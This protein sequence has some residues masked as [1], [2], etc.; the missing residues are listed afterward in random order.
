M[1]R[2]WLL[3]CL[4]LSTA[5]MGVDVRCP[6]CAGTGLVSARCCKTCNSRGKITP[7]INKVMGQELG[8]RYRGTTKNVYVDADSGLLRCP[9]KPDSAMKN[10]EGF[11]ALV[12][13]N[14][15]Q[16]AAV[17]FSVKKVPGFGLDE[18]LAVLKESYPIF[19]DFTY[20]EERKTKIMQNRNDSKYKFA[21]KHTDRFFVDPHC[22]RVI[23]VLD[24]ADKVYLQ[25][26]D[27]ALY[28]TVRT[29]AIKS[30]NIGTTGL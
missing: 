8:E 16:I 26:I 17:T 2:L 18:L 5:L 15:K 23:L 20:R 13:P 28:R 10:A 12:T 11:T 30:S 25:Y 19:L 1:K 3:C 6:D 21:A 22:D 4:V 7:Q 24:M 27:I 14:Y 29:E 9:F